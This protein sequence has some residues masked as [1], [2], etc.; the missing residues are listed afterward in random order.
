MTAFSPMG[1]PLPPCCEACGCPEDMPGVGT[2]F[3]QGC[4]NCGMP[5]QI[6]STDALLDYKTSLETL[7]HVIIAWWTEQV[8]AHLHSVLPEPYFVQSARKYI[9]RMHP[10]SP[11]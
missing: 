5:L 6:E 3:V 1:F 10:Q 9:V 11:F 2:D 4:P 8:A 7:C